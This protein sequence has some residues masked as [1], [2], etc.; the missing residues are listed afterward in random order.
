MARH[1]LHGVPDALR[2]GSVLQPP[3]LRQRRPAPL[4]HHGD[5][6]HVG[7]LLREAGDVRHMDGKLPHRLRGKSSASRGPRSGHGAVGHGVLEI[8]NELFVTGSTGYSRK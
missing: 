7:Q 8:D 6:E 3:R 2:G 5:D 1:A 4:L